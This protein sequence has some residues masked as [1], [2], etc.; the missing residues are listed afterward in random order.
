[1]VVRHAEQQNP[2]F[3]LVL[4]S[5]ESTVLP[6]KSR[7]T[8]YQMQLLFQQWR[9]AFGSRRLMDL[10]PER[11][12]RWRDCW[13]S[14]G[15]APSTVAQRLW[16][17][18]GILRWVTE[19]GLLPVNPMTQVIKPCPSARPPSSLTT[20][21][22]QRLLA[23]CQASHNPHLYPLA[24]LM[25]ATRLRKHHLCAL[26]W[27]GLDLAR[28]VLFV[29]EARTPAP[30]VPLPEPVLDLLRT[31]QAL[32]APGVPWVFPSRTGTGPVTPY[33][34]WRKACQQAGLSGLR[35]E[36]LRHATC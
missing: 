10:T 14:R 8:I 13:L 1:M 25:V 5:Y 33:Y 29:P 22:L 9:Q 20:E 12:S 30:W 17:L 2:S 24:L 11:L 16:I 35:F 19:Q 31:R 27:E 23:A 6:F 3:H 34:G 26:R 18:Q 15:L 7:R 32:R 4:T 36:D 21:G 28:G